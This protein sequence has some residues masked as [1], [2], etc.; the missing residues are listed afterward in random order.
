MATLFYAGLLVLG[1]VLLV[2][3]V[4]GV[5][6]GGIGTGDGRASRPAGTE[7]T[8]ARRILDERYAA[9]QLGTEEYHHRRR[10]L[11]ERSP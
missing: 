4:A 7:R 8:S 3:T 1:V 10:V 5:L 2:V 11:E 9:G 6:V